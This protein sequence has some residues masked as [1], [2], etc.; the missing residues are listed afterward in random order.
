MSQQD[1]A[2]LPDL[3]S[4]PSQKK[5]RHRHTPAQLAALNQLFEQD[6]HPSL[7]ARSVLAERET[8]TVN[9][10]FQNKRAST[11]KRSKGAASVD[12]SQPANPMPG[13]YPPVSYPPH[14]SEY[15]DYPDEEYPPPPSAPY[16]RASS[17]MPPDLPPFYY[18]NNVD[19][20]YY[21]SESDAARRIRLRPSSD[22]IEELKRLYNINPH[23]TA[24]ERQ[25]L[26]ERIGMRYQSITNWFQNQRSSAKKKREDETEISIPPKPPSDYS[27]DMRQ[28]S[29][30]PPPT[31]HPS[32]PLPPMPIQPPSLT[33]QN[34]R[35]SP[36]LPPVDD[37]SP[38]R[39]Y[40][41]RST[42]PYGSMPI[43]FSRP[44]RSRPEPYQLD[45]LKELF[46]KTSTPTIEERSALALEI[47][48][49]VGKVTNWFRN[50]RQTA[51]KR[52][53]KSGS[54]DDEEYNHSS[55]SAAVSRSGTPS[56]GSS[57]SSSSVHDDTTDSHAIDNDYDM[58]PVAS[59][60]GSDEDYQEVLT[61]SPNHSPSPAPVAAADATSSIST[62]GNIPSH[63]PVP[64]PAYYAE[65]EKVSATRYSGI[66]IEDALLLLSFHQHVIH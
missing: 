54:G 38:R 36:S 42:T 39:T 55:I 24:E 12:T 57:S 22:Q 65:L 6:E 58:Q 23:P 50:L 16:S 18:T 30:F 7:E 15:D 59:D 3:D 33:H 62:V 35:R 9:A 37:M 4:K 48:M 51:R 34:L 25:A 56:L 20:S 63:T 17:V 1:A 40:P 31:Q 27:H 8:K 47:G 29:A 10:W 66:R 49:D 26:A 45:A 64:D 2:S 43:S 5:P 32:L 61:P 13:Q 19:S 21:M 44:R 53:K 28:Y 60:I 14:R 11:K 52:A 46:Q 41:R